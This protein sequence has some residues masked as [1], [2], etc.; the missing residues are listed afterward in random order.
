VLGDLGELEFA[1]GNVSRALQFGSEALEILTRGKDANSLMYCY[2]QISMCRLALG[3]LEKARDAALQSLYCA[4]QAY[5]NVLD[6]AIALQLFALLAALRR[7]M[8]EAARLIGY[9]NVQ[10][11][12]CG[13]ERGFIEKLVY[14]KLMAALRGRLRDEEIERLAAEGARWSED[15]AVAEA[16]KI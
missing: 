5:S 6:I 10:Y 11:K 13:L 1:D 8:H 7:K 14:D 12:D 2:G 4:R 15:H 16:L 3:E 9:V